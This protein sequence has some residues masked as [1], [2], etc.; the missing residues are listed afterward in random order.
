MSER[1]LGGITRSG[2]SNDVV[3]ASVAYGVVVASNG[4]RR[5]QHQMEGTPMQVTTLYGT[6]TISETPPYYR[7]WTGKAIVAAQR[8]KMRKRP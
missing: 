1:L 7:N 3:L 8:K 4:T 6:V 2:N 5:R